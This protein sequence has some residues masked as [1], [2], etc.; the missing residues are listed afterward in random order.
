MENR[1]SYTIVGVFFI[2]C[3][4]FFGL[5]AWW[6]SIKGDPNSQYKEYFV[7]AK[8]LP[9][10]VKDGTAVRFSGITAGFVKSINFVENSDDIEITLNVKENM[11]VKKDS[12]AKVEVQGIS[13]IAVIN[14]TK[15]YGE[16][17]KHNERAQLGFDAGLFSKIGTQAETAAESI[18][19]ILQKTNMALTEEN[20]QKFSDFM[21][22]LDNFSKTIGSKENL[23]NINQILSR[24]NSIMAKIDDNS[25]GLLQN[26]NKLISDIDK[27]ALSVSST[28]KA[29]EISNKK[30]DYN[31]NKILTPTMDELNDVLVELK[32]SLVDFKDSVNRLE[33]SP[34]EFFFNSMKTPEVGVEK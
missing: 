20:L 23:E 8:E 33:N 12:I 18:N 19:A 15:G 6:L 21:S 10:G 11:P 3:L 4:L 17:F 2:L 32:R 29:F 34:F 16:R 31:L 13:G 5:F 25:N 30:G 7:I 28:A 14:I 22:T 24:A 9:N 1:N 26:T 27:L